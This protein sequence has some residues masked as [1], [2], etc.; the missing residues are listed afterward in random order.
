MYQK[1]FCWKE[2]N[3]KKNNNYTIITP[4]KKWFQTQNI[5]HINAYQTA[6]ELKSLC[7]YVFIQQLISVYA[8]KI[9]ICNQFKYYCTRNWDESFDT[10]GYTLKMDTIQEGIIF[11]CSAEIAWKCFDKKLS[12]E[13]VTQRCSVKNG[14]LKDFAKLQVNTCVEV[15]F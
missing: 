1:L 6:I 14:I 7:S 2:I 12:T 3:F 5:K 13:A 10:A 8:I 9:I 11:H 4:C 15:S